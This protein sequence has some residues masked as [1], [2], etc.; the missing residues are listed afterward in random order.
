MPAYGFSGHTLTRTAFF[1]FVILTPSAQFV[2]N[3]NGF[4]QRP[5]TT[6]GMTQ[7]QILLET[8]RLT[9]R[10]F[11][12][13][14]AEHLFA[15]DNDPVVMRYINGGTPISIE[16][17]KREILP[18]FLRHDERFPMYGFWAAID[19]TSHRFLGWFVFRTLG[20]DPHKVEIGYRFYQHAWGFGYATEG[21]RALMD[22]GFRENGVTRVT[23]TA[24]EENRASRRVMEKLGMTLQRSFRITSKDIANTDT[25][26]TTSA[27][28]WDGYDVEYSLGIL[29]WREFKQLPESD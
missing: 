5:P 2:L 1:V 13:D 29:E 12:P 8:R 28:V 10:P 15:L 6:T 4:E 9:L 26:H 17:I 24:Y 18:V 14:D 21:A 19:K 22:K 16:I 23:A 7:V 20:D 25:A 11:T 27:E 3:P